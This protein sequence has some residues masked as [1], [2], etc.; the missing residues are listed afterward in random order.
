MGERTNVDSV[1][2]DVEHG[3][4][5]RGRGRGGGRGRGSE[6]SSNE[7]DAKDG[8]HESDCNDHGRKAE[9]GWRVFS[10]HSGRW[11]VGGG[12]DKR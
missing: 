4:R 6:E 5:G 12:R 9:A 11:A 2:R 1:G 10:G 7:L 8:S 3:V